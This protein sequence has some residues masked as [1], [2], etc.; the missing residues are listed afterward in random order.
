MI[1]SS[2]LLPLPFGPMIPKNSPCC[3][4]EAHVV[5][6]LLHLVGRAAKGWRKYSLSV[7]RRSCGSRKAFETP[8]TSIARPALTRAPRTTALR[9]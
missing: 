7:V 8:E 3:D 2:V 4:R 6:R 9:A 5:E 1:L